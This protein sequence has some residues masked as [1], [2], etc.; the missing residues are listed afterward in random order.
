MLRGTSPPLSICTNASTL[1]LSS[2][3]GALLHGGGGRDRLS[4]SGEGEKGAEV[5]VG[6]L[7]ARIEA[8]LN[9]LDHRCGVGSGGAG[10]GHG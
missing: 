5:G 1:S 8:I 3:I 6:L 2:P 9:A 10:R 4:T 7:A